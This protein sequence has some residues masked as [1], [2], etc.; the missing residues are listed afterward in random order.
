MKTYLV[1]GAV[2][3]QLLG[4]PVQDRDWVVLGATSQEMIERGFVQVGKDFPVFLHPETKEEY[5][6]A[7]TERKT[8]VGYGGFEVHADP[9]VTLE[10]D[11]ARRDLTIN[12]IAMDDAGKII[13]PYNGMAAIK[14]CQ[15]RHVTEA[16]AEDP[17]RVLR[18]ARFKAR[19]HRC[20]FDIVPETLKLMGDISRSGELTELVAERVWGELEKALMASS[21]SQFF[22][23]LKACEALAVLFPEIS[24]LFGV[25]QRKDYHPEI[26][27]GIH[28]MMVLEQAAEMKSCL[29]VRFAS[30]VHDLGKADTPA[31]ILPKHIGH[32]QR[33]IKRVNEMCARL[34]IPKRCSELGLLVAKYHTQCHQVFSLKPTTVL[35]LLEK[36]DSFRRPERLMQFL[37]ACKADSLGRKGFEETPYPQYDF[38]LEAHNVCKAV[39][40]QPLLAK[41]IRGAEINIALKRE[42]TCAIAQL[43]RQS[44]IN[45]NTT[46]STKR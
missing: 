20:G 36:L 32:E 3:D 19:F 5:A 2:R 28:T 18:V 33:S 30:L 14:K 46:P 10:E 37:L 26:D 44:E 11:L 27:T 25:E 34:K 35:K 12:A 41:G 23:S 16:F 1:G 38:L 24:N 42:R 39:S 45:S 31:N 40:V 43:K 7:R 4:I 21:P 9:S 13:D 8:G 17:L 6:L 22:L 29:E 15:L